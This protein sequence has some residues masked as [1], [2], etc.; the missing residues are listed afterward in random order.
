PN[1][2]KITSCEERLKE[3][4]STLK[5]ELDSR[6]EALNREYREVSQTEQN[7]LA[8][9]NQAKDEAFKLNQNEEDYQR[10]KRAMGNIQRLYDVVLKR[11]KDASISGLVQMSNVRIVD[12]ARPIDVPVRPSVYLNLVF[13]AL[14]GI[15]LGA[16]TTLCLEYFNT[17]VNNQEQIDQLGLS[18]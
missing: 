7:L 1:H 4:R 13:G 6:L 11:L 14:L 15:L 5:N 18:F 2:P 17:T 10:L 9:Y 16:L 8:L 12:R 3:V